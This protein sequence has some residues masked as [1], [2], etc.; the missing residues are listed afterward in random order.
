MS[1]IINIAG[2][3]VVKLNSGSAGALQEWG[4]TEEGV[5]VREEMLTLNIPGDQNA[6]SEGNPIDIQDLG[7]VGH[8]HLEM[9]KFDP[10]VAQQVIAKANTNGTSPVGQGVS[11]S[12]GV[13]L[14]S[15]SLYFRLLILPTNSAFIR[16]FLIAVPIEAYEMNISAKY[17][18]FVSDWICSP[19]VGGGTYWN[20][21]GT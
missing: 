4:Y 14:F 16:N 3:A 5:M 17:T 19:P 8:V 20:M 15:N 1:D 11:P 7:R 21:T 10:V 6:G 9:S 18:R 2:P 13:L 12:P